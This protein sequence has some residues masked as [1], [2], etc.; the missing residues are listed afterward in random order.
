M[1]MN[2]WNLTYTQSPSVF[3]SSVDP[4]FVG[5][6]FGFVITCVTPAPGPTVRLDIA[7]LDPSSGKGLLVYLYMLRRGLAVW[8]HLYWSSVLGMRS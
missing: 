7:N 6:N 1:R 4:V 8:R 2:Q 5:T 3:Y